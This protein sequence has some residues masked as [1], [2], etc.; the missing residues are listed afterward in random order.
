MK[1]RRMWGT[2]ATLTAVATWGLSVAAMQA[3]SLELSLSGMESHLGQ[4]LEAR[5]VEKAT[6]AEIA[7][8]RVDP[9]EAGAFAL[10]FTG[11]VE[12]R[13][14]LVEVYVDQN[15]NARYDAP[16]TDAAWRIEVVA[17]GGVIQEAF[18]RSADFVDIAWRD[19]PTRGAAVDGVVRDGEYPSV[20]DD[21]ETGMVVRWRVDGA[22]LTMALESPGSGWAAAGFDPV[23]GMDGADFILV[24]VTSDGVIVEDHIGT[25]RVRHSLDA[26]QDVLAA[27]GIEEG[28]RTVVEFT[29]AL[30]SGDPQDATLT[31]EGEHVLL[32]AFHRSS[33][34]LGSRH[35]ERSATLIRLD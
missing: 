20:L 10:G 2:L 28:E 8:T 17:A 31:A 15:G 7:R 30:M 5:V 29:I 33:D 25:S 22:T 1:T 13:S 3:A 19:A 27:W 24:A 11:L 35:T 16:P 9:V 21:D 18:V 14:Y 26:R 34:D 23:N 6:G 12:A 4:L 32:L